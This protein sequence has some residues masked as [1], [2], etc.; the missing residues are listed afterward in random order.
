MTV[1]STLARIAYTIS[2]AGPYS[3]PFYFLANADLIVIRTPVSGDPVTLV[4][5]TD[6]TVT[7][8]GLEAGGALTLVAP[9]NGSTLTIINEPPITQ[10][11]AYPETGKF[12]AKSHETALDKLTMAMKRV[13]DLASRG[14]RL[15]DGDAA[16]SFV[17]PVSSPGKL[18]GWNASG[19]LTNTSPSAVG[20]G[21]I[22]SAELADNS[23][24]T[25]ELVN[26][27]VTVA[28][29][30]D[31]EL[32]A[33]AALSTQQVT[34]L[35]SLSAFIGGLLNDTD[36]AAA[37]ATL[38]ALNLQF[39]HVRDEKAS[40]T[41]GGSSISGSQIRTLNTV[42]VNTITG[43]TL[44]TN[45]VTLPAGTYRIFASAP[46]FV[47]NRHRLRLVN[48]TDATVAI[49]GK[50]AYT[51]NTDI[52]ST[53]A[54]VNGRIVITGTKAFNLTHYINTA[55]TATGLGVDI[56]DT[57]VEVYADLMIWKE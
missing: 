52:V 55:Q 38:G 47:A 26:G 34:D 27:S 30:A 13:Y 29:I 24:G 50:S 51:G 8:A 21:T 49:L 19:V 56:S 16:T 43:A 5:T 1:Q 4:L 3:I 57:F 46:A 23:V 9:V 2:G 41:Q 17:F 36:A 28:K 44:A 42:V 53:D 54:I 20:P 11:T 37:R 7:G 33:L 18:I 6:Y 39:M 15:N 22:T 31:A 14:L 45:Q 12:P 48:V 25:T 10:L 40:G 35:L 32:V